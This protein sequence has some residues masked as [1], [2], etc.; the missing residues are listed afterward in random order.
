MTKRV[1]LG[2]L[3]AVAV[4]FGSGCRSAVYSTYEKFGVY[5]RDLLKKRVVEARVALLIFECENYCER[6]S[7]NCQYRRWDRQESPL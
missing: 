6:R 5:K 3:M 4:V 7:D 2:V 1:W